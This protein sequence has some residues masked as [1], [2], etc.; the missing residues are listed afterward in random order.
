MRFLLGVC[1]SQGEQFEE[2]NVNDEDVEWLQGSNEAE[3]N[4]LEVAGMLDDTDD[5]PIQT[6]LVVNVKHGKGCLCY[7]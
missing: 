4:A 2:P 3:S 6:S 5:T 7:T 1:S